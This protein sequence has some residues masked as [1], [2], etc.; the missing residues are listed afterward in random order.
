MKLPENDQLLRL[1]PGK[2]DREDPDLW[3][4][5]WMHLEDTAGIM[6]RLIAHWL[7][8]NIARFIESQADGRDMAS[9]GKL[10]A[11]LHDIGKFTPVFASRILVHLPEIRNR[12]E[13]H[14]FDIP[15]VSFFAANTPHALAGQCILRKRQV[16][17]GISV[18]IGAHHGIPQGVL[19]SDDMEIYP[20][21]YYGRKGAVSPYKELW[22][23][24]WDQW[25][26][27]ALQKCGYTSVK[28]LPVLDQP[29]QMLLT[30]LLIMADWIASNPYYFPLI[31]IDSPGSEDLYPG[32]IDNAWK[33]FEKSGMQ[34]WSPSVFYADTDAFQNSFRFI[35]PDILPNDVQR[36]FMDVLN[37]SDG[38]GIYILEAPMGCGKTE[39]ALFAAEILAAKTQTSGVFFGLP[40]QATA[41]GIFTRLLPWAKAQSEETVQSIR[42]AHGMAE[43]NEDYRSL[44]EGNAAVDD[45][46]AKTNEE[47]LIVHEWFRGRKQALLSDFVI[48]TVDQMLLA[49]LSRKHVMLRHLGLAGKVVII[50]ECH[51]YDAYMNIY[52]DRVLGWLG[53]YGT[54]VVIL[55][56]TLPAKRRSEL[57]RAYVG[58]KNL[59]NADDGWETNRAYPLLTWTEGCM[60]H[61]L[62]IPYSGRQTEVLIRRIPD[63]AVI[64]DLTEALSDGGCAGVIVNTV[65]RAQQLADL[66]EQ[67]VPDVEVL[68]FHAQFIAPDRAEREQDLLERIG[69]KSTPEQ[70]NRLVV[71][72]TQVLEQSLDIDFDYMITDLCPMDLLLQRIGRLHRHDRSRPGKL[73]RACCSVLGA[74]GPDFLKAS[75]MIYG[76]WMLEQTAKLLPE[77]ITLPNDIPDLVQEAYAD[78]EK[79]TDEWNAYRMNILKKQGKADQ[80][81]IAKPMPLNSRRPDRN[82][83]VRLLDNA[84]PENTETAEAG[85]R[86]GIQSIGVLLMKQYRD[87]TVGFLP[88]SENG[89]LVRR[90]HK[91]DAEES[92]K[93]ARQKINLPYIFNVGDNARQAISELEHVKKTVL[94]EWQQSGLLKGELILLLDE[95]NQAD[96]CGYHLTYSREKGLS[97]AKNGKEEKSNNE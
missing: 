65:A 14:G 71:V 40:T 55:S 30:G 56:A 3:L 92:R 6:N 74:S 63:E 46:G 58:A 2:T 4:P 12:L 76:L 24:L 23:S 59:L 95:D 45:D 86:D 66:I 15:D 72:G 52:M 38:H 27:Y 43:L 19:N 35:S 37:N 78:S 32:R 21:N 42:L 54:P 81:C 70:R 11:Y 73:L 41:N 34:I 29:A 36:G 17:A 22:D 91:P 88:W 96:L 89:A 62:A 68:L 60:A 48:G 83:I 79:H 44:F 10:T 9:I 31:H 57:V 8:P 80:F 97:A 49:G 39:A 53:S 85:V 67:S 75:V 28:D 47:K 13:N 90:D 7:P 51:A 33:K 94:P 26:V 20:E 50:D 84:H 61:S 5:V 25:L 77:K 64:S 18:I 16:P 69:K 82:T 1:L 93:I 87:G